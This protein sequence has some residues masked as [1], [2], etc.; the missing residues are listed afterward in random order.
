MAE[1]TVLGS[2]LLEELGPGHRGQDQNKGGLETIF[3]G[4]VDDLIEDLGSV[5]VKSYHKGA[6]HADFSLVETPDTI[7]VLS[8]FI[9]ELVHLIHVRLG[10]RFEANVH[11]DAT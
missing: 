7:G 4:E 10:E 11:S 2:H 8:R 1:D 5:F 6:H 3:H 9:G